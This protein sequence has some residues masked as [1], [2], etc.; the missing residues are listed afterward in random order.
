MFQ[1]HKP[2][3][4]SERELRELCEIGDFREL[5]LEVLKS[6]L[7]AFAEIH[8]RND[9]QS[10]DFASF[11]QRSAELNKIANQASVLRNSL[12]TMHLDTGLALRS[13]Q[14]A[15]N[16]ISIRENKMAPADPSLIL[17]G[18]EVSDDPDLVGVTIG[19][20]ELIAFL[21]GLEVAAKE[22]KKQLRKRP[23]KK[24][25]DYGLRMWLI[26]VQSKWPEWTDRPFSRDIDSRGE[27]ITW[28]AR[29]CV[30]AFRK[31]E[32]TYTKSRIL[33]GLKNRLKESR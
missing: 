31:V 11:Q 19:S 17:A 27:P 4:Y 1:S 24:I 10:N 28:A 32:P 25:P 21:G 30:Q 16:L 14:D 15:Q 2:D 7:N 6:D 26:N 29:F 9:L 8:F 23:S 3:L 13:Q 22:A 18:S 20:K 12:Q 5:D 33:N